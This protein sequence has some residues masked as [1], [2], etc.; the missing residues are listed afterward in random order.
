MNF[1]RCA[2]QFAKIIKDNDKVKEMLEIYK[3][4]KLLKKIQCIIIFLI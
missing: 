1:Y 2:I 3:K 4:I